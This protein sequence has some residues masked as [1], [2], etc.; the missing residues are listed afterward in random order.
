M[1]VL[2]GAFIASLVLISLHVWG[3]SLLSW[4]LSQGD[5][6]DWGDVCKQPDYRYFNGGRND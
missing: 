5:T 2:T 1:R 4:L 3:P 6:T